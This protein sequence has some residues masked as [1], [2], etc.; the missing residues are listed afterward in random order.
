MNAHSTERDRCYECGRTVDVR[1]RWK[2]ELE[3]GE[4]AGLALTV[5]VRP[6]TESYNR[7]GSIKVTG[8]RCPGSNRPAL[9]PILRKAREWVATVASQD[10][11]D[12]MVEYVRKELGS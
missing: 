7:D 11:A 10:E 12:E 5:H 3:A 9:P 4:D 1:A 8:V 6:G 2:W